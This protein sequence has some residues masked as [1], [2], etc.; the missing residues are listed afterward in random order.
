[1]S[2]I[3]LRLMGRFSAHDA[4]G[5]A[6]AVASLK[7]RLLLACLAI[8][9]ETERTRKRLSAFLWEDRPQE[10]AQVSLR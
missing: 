10:Q 9:P 2:F 3:R 7:G 4:D 5:R 1:M 6:V 8:R